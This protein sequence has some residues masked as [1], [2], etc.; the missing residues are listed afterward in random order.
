MEDADNLLL[1]QLK[2]LGVS[3]KSLEDF[4]GESFCGTVILCLARLH[5]QQSSEE[6]FIDLPFLKKQNL[7]EATHRFKVCQK[8]VKYLQH[9]GYFYDVSFTTFTNPEVKE[10]R[11]LLG[12]F[13]ELIFKGADD[14]SGKETRPTNQME[15]I[16]KRR[17][18]KF[19]RKPWILPD[20]LD[21]QKRGLLIGGE[22]IQVQKDIDFDRVAACKSKKAKGVYKM[23]LDTLS[24]T[25]AAEE[26]KQGIHALGRSLQHSAWAKGQLLLGE[27]TDMFRNEEDDD[28]GGDGQ[29]SGGLKMINKAGIMGQIF[30]SMQT[31]QSGSGTLDVNM[32]DTGAGGGPKTIAEILEERAQQLKDLEQFGD[33]KNSQFVDALAAD[34]DKAGGAGGMS[35]PVT[36]GASGADGAAVDTDD[37]AQALGAGNGAGASGAADSLA[38]EIQAKFE[39]DTAK[40]VEENEAAISE[41]V[42]TLEGLKAEIGASQHKAEQMQANKNEFEEEQKDLV[43]SLKSTQKAA[44]KKKE[45]LTELDKLQGQ[46]LRVLQNEVGAISGELEQLKDEWEEYKKPINEE[47]FEKKQ[48]IADK[49]VEYQYKQEKIK[50]LKGE[51]KAVVQ[52][53]EHKKRVHQ[54]ME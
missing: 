29:G 47:I 27:R 15:E 11:K 9:L 13:F 31:V 6:Q 52:D 16:L 53:I 46:D 20:F 38:N 25:R 24:I 1:A 4:T 8:F 43:D 41:M 3:L 45:V 10:T 33:L 30:S 35:L 39:A 2:S 32:P 40:L 37:A 49:R 51:F 14:S 18:T 34:I 21:G 42:V 44:K 17:L 48:E 7:K 23:M 36:S 28:E 22:V 26:Y 54:F 12:F 50:A 19:S 5:S